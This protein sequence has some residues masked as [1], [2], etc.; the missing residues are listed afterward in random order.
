MLCMDEQGDPVKCLKYGREVTN[1]G[2]R[3]FNLV[4]A[5]CLKPFADYAHCLDH[6]GQKLDLEK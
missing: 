4:K 3:F 6:C 1:C 2:W 5:N